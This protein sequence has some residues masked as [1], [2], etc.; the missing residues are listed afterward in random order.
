MKLETRL[1]II[2]APVLV[3][4]GGCGAVHFP[5]EYDAANLTEVNQI[6]NNADLTGQE[7]REQLIAL[8]IDE[9]E[10]RIARLTRLPAICC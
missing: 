4:A 7:K 1:L 6:R 2:L 9:A 10:P 5:G 8:G 3:A